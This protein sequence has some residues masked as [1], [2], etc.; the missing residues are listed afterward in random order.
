M[1]RDDALK[2]RAEATQDFDTKYKA[3]LD[4]MNRQNEQ[5]KSEVARVTS[6]ILEQRAENERHIKK[7]KGD[8][9][10]QL[11]SNI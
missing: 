3:L 2:Q 5:T 6:E 8:F 10:A 11:N 1:Q 9:E 4:R 7:L